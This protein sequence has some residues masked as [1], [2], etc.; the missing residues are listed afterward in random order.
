VTLESDAVAPDGIEADGIAPDAEIVPAGRSLKKRLLLVG[1]AALLLAAIGIGYTVWA[2][3]R[4]TDSAYASGDAAPASDPGLYLHDRG[5]YV[6]LQDG[7]GKVTVDDG[8]TT[9]ARTGTG[10]DCLR[11]YAAGDTAVCV[12]PQGGLKPMTTVEILDAELEVKETFTF[13]GVPSRARVSP[14]GKLIAWTLFVTGD[15]YAGTNF[16]TRTGLYNVETNYLVDSVEGLQ[17]YI[18]GR[19]VRRPDV[20]YWGIT[21]ADDN[22]FYATVSVGGK[23]HLVKGDVEAWTATAIRENVECPSLS[24]DG[25]RLV[26]KKRVNEGVEDP[27]RL[28][29]LDLATMQEEPLAE[30]RSID[31]QAAWL[32]DGT[33]AY[34]IDGDVWSVPADGSGEPTLIAPD[35][36]SPALVG[37]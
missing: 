16:S 24:P 1:G 31:D 4:P 21:F 3:A 22:T 36:S 34:A 14:S 18:D 5:G 37:G 12:R 15:N 8:S 7:G 30:D 29:V 17:L 13:D 20:N 35:A 2:G 28:H 26:F 9:P 10:L 27:W 6:V 23:T 33:V 32:D 11:F 19:R 25:T